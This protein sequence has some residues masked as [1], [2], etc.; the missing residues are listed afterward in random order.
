MTLGLSSAGNSFAGVSQPIAGESLGNERLYYSLSLYRSANSNVL[1][2]RDLD[3]QVDQYGRPYGANAIQTKVLL[4]LLTE[5]GSVLGDLEFGLEPLPRTLSV[6]NLRLLESNVQTALNY[7]VSSNQIT[8]L[9]IAASVP[10]PARCLLHI[11]YKDMSS[12]QNIKSLLEL[13]GI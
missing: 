2:L 8:Q 1:S 5:K 11:E 6:A 12:N 7:L 4:T 9:Y 3:Y 13:N 10:S